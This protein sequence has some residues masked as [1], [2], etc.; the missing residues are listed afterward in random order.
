MRWHRAQEGYFQIDHRASP[1]TLQVPGGQNYESATA[2]CKHCSI[3]ITLDPRR[4]KPKE[5][6]P[7]CDGYI[8][9]VCSLAKKQP[10]YIHMGV[11]QLFDEHEKLEYQLIQ[12]R[13]I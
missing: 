5:Y 11:K 13:K 8:C 12:N 3:P 2:T 6:C 7:A 1:G 4:T 10:G 9:S